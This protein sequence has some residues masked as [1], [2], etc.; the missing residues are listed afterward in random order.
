MEKQDAD[1]MEAVIVTSSEVRRL[2]LCSCGKRQMNT[3]DT[4]KEGVKGDMTH[5]W[6]E[7]E[8]MSTVI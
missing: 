1:L 4:L 3:T 7:T 6:I 8:K 5:E 2:E